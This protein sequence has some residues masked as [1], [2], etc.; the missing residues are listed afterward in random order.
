LT[1]KVRR[2]HVH[3]VVQLRNQ[4]IVRVRRKLFSPLDRRGTCAGWFGALVKNKF[5]A[6]LAI[7]GDSTNLASRDGAQWQFV[8]ELETRGKAAHGATPH[9]AKMPSTKMPAS[10]T[11][12]NRLHG[13]VASSKT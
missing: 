4:K 3:G 1:P 2:R 10:W 6:D 5:K 7:V 12:G 11:F 9:S 13:A 8:L